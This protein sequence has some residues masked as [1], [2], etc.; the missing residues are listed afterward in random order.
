MKDFKI[1]I[2]LDKRMLGRL[3]IPKP[4]KIEKPKRGK[5][6]YDRKNTRKPSIHEP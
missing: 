2:E 4:G 6:S 1:V 5:G 3:P